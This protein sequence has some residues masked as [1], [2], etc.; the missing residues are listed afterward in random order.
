M[1]AP[2]SK[3]A[4]TGHVWVYGKVRRLLRSPVLKRVLCSDEEFG[5][6]GHN[7]KVFARLNRAELGDFDSLVLGLFLMAHFKGQIIVPDF[8]FYGREAH[9]G[10]MREGRLIGRGQLS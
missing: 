5:F 9:A 1:I 10:L 7:R 4:P 8:G 2:P 6:T 3:N